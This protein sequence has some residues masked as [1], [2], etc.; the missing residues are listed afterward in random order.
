MHIGRREEGDQVEP[1]ITHPTERRQLPAKSQQG[2]NASSRSPKT[3]NLRETSQSSN[4]KERE[5]TGRDYFD[6]ASYSEYTSNSF[7]PE[8]EVNIGEWSSNGDPEGVGDID[9]EASSNGTKREKTHLNE[10]WKG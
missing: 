3:S 5:S 2:R 7:L 6:I 4:E 8:S 1:P 10:I 9:W